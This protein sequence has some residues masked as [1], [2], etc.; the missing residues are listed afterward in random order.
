MD[1]RRLTDW[2]QGKGLFY[3]DAVALLDRA[4]YLNHE[5]AAPVEPELLDRVAEAIEGAVAKLNDA[6]TLL[7]AEAEQ[8][9]SEA[10]ER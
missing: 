5:A 9:P 6:T 7:A 4:G 3:E 8:P 1:P 10:A 2:R